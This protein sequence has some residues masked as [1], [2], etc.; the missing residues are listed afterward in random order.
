MIE[1]RVDFHPVCAAVAAADLLPLRANEQSPL[2]L[3]V[4]PLLA[5]SHPA[6]PD[7]FAPPVK[8]FVGLL[9]W[10]S[11]EQC[12][13]PDAA[14]KRASEQSLPFFANPLCSLARTSLDLTDL[15]HPPNRSTLS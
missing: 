8:S 9:V 1:A 15:P 2:H 4:T 6:A 11:A 3:P 5:R 14:S 10:D 7:P 13:F 12:S